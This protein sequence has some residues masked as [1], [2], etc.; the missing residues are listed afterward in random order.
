MTG[1]ETEGAMVVY[2]GRQEPQ[3]NEIQDAEVR[4]G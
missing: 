2:K 4:C 1:G 3:N